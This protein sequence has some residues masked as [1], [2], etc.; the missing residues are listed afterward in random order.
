M[1]DEEEQQSQQ[2]KNGLVRRAVNT[3]KKV[4]KSTASKVAKNSKKFAKL[5][6]IL[7][8]HLPLIIT[9]G[10]II[11]V[12]LFVFAIYGFVTSMP[13]LVIGKLIE[14]GKS[15]WS[16]VTGFITGDYD[17]ID[18]EDVNE[19][20]QYLENMGYSVQGYGFADVKYT[21]DSEPT[22]KGK[23]KKVELV[24]GVKYR[25]NYLHSYLAANE[26]TY[27]LAKYS[28]WGDL[29]A[30]GANL[31]GDV[32]AIKQKDVSHYKDYSS[33]LL[34]IMEFVGPHN[35]YAAGDDYVSVDRDS[36]TLDISQYAFKYLPFLPA[37]RFGM[38]CSYDLSDWTA[39]YG[40]P[41]EMFLALHI[42][43]GMP[44]LTY[45]IA[46]D[47][48]F[49]TKVNIEAQSVTIIYD[50]E[51]KYEIYSP[52][53]NKIS[54]NSIDKAYYKYILDKVKERRNTYDQSDEAEKDAYEAWDKVYEKLRVSNKDTRRKFLKLFFGYADGTQ[55]IFG[56]WIR[57]P[58][59]E[60]YGES[61]TMNL[62]IPNITSSDN[63]Y[64]SGI[65]NEQLMYL[66]SLIYENK[67]G[68]PIWL[69]YISSV[70]KHW[71]YEDIEFTVGKTG[72]YEAA[73]YARKSIKYQ[74]EDGPIKDFDITINNALL[75]DD[76]GKGILFQKREPYTHGPNESIK[77]LFFNNAYYRYDGTIDTAE[78]IA[79]TILIKEEGY[80]AGDEYV[81]NGEI[82]TLTSEDVEA[83]NND[84]LALRQYPSFGTPQDTLSA[85]NILRKVDSLEA[86][87]SYRCLKELATS[88][89]AIRE[90]IKRSAI[91][92]DLKQVLLW[93]FK[94]NSDGSREWTVEKTNEDYGIMVK[95]V[96]GQ[97]MIAP[98]DCQ[99]R[100]EDGKLVLKFGK[101]KSYKKG[102]SNYPGT[103]Q[104]LRKHFQQK[105][106]YRVK[107]DEVYEMEMIIEGISNAKTGSID[108][109][110][111]IGK[112]NDEV[113]ITMRH[114][115]KS[116]VGNNNNTVD[117]DIEEYMNQN[118]TD[119]DEAQVKK[120]LENQKDV[121]DGGTR[122]GGDYDDDYYEGSDEL[123]IPEVSGEVSWKIWCA[124][125]ANGYSDE[126]AAGVLGNIQ[127]ES[128][129]D[130]SAVNKSSGASGLA[131]WLGKRKSGLLA[132]AS[133]KGVDWTD[134]N[135]QIEFLLCEIGDG[136]CNGHA[137]KQLM[138]VYQ[139]EYDGWLNANTPEEGATYFA[140]WFE[141]PATTVEGCKKYRDTGREKRAKQ[142]YDQYHGKS[143][144][145][146]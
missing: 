72:V 116:L 92:E 96:S 105:D 126:S 8:T 77:N 143:A 32:Q 66:I 50:D 23:T 41:T 60:T 31:T 16:G 84:L 127:S 54:R 90:P 19:L 2:Q 100:M 129:F 45:E 125:K 89:E 107:V 87:T 78:K 79:K 75:H 74:E 139:D 122:T 63:E 123:I 76:T 120:V 14:V 138:S 141:R 37:Y 115:D 36:Q 135:T 20:A 13:G 85:F 111:S 18:D 1:N 22:H 55:N 140:R 145:D 142:W 81:F 67:D 62:L 144:N 15:F 39:K 6:T 131:Q 47:N 38:T 102:S 25:N 17:Y 134:V 28:I 88:A 33:G 101:L 121:A 70:Q 106:F 86:E 109:G 80:S 110:E 93:A 56:C 132:Y 40:R 53:G 42:A 49:N 68:V 133:D 46:T 58:Y 7:L 52:E 71:F 119:Y 43:T 10:I 124:L 5:L 137:R 26:E 94:D 73:E 30:F 12:I 64:M 69:P 57:E 108:R 118:Y 34:K 91:T 97:E 99:A 61:I 136:G 98:G 65:T 35:T 59:N 48:D 113:K 9:I 82:H 29:Q 24:T 95:D 44:D 103:V 4:A 104:I 146:S 11:L 27:E 128:G 112:A 114:I 3:G 83:V 51:T 130:P 117:D 21:D